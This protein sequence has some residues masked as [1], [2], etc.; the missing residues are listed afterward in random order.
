MVIRA[1][2]ATP[3]TV[4]TAFERMVLERGDHLVL[5]EPWSRA[6]YLGPDRR[7]D[8]FPLCFP[9]A[10]YEAVSA[11]VL[12]LVDGPDVFVKDMAYQAAPGLSDDA[13]S[14]I[15]HTFLIRRPDD[16]LTSL[17]RRW[18]D[19]SEDEAGYLAQVTLFERIRSVTGTDPVVVDSDDLR[20]DPSRVVAAWCAAVGLDHRPEA[21]TWAPGMRPEWPLWRDWYE[22]VAVSTGFAPPGVRRTDPGSPAVDA[23]VKARAEAAYRTLTRYRMTL[24]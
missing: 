10:T 6:Y 3:R 22:N 16:A 19:H 5:D 12:G 23:D 15:T 7:S 4:S 18:P 2:W 13:L 20:A 14:Q 21:L 8:R 1:L 9:E 24:G 11:G 17:A